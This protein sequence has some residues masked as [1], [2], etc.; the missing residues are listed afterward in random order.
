VIEDQEPPDHRSLISARVRRELGAGW[1][2]N[3]KGECFRRWRQPPGLHE[4]QHTRTQRGAAHD[5]EDNSCT[6]ES[7]AAFHDTSRR[8]RRVLES[9]PHTGDVVEAPALISLETSPQH[10]NN[11]GRRCTRQ[12]LPVRLRLEHRGE[13]VGGRAARE[14]SRTCEHLEQHAAERPDVRLPADR[15]PARLLRAKLKTT[16]VPKILAALP[17]AKAAR[18]VQIENKIRAVIRY[19]MAAGIPLVK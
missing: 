7:T 9:D 4:R 10:L 6:R 1:S 8:Q 19:E 17:A 12:R 2:K 18:Y 3:G 14:G 13:D 11:C 16:Y 15:E 5:G